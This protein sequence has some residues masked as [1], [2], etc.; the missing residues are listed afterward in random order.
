MLFMPRHPERKA[1]G[2]LRTQGYFKKSLPDK[3][4]VTVITV[5]YNGV[6]YL[7]ATIRSVIKQTH[8][9][10]EYVIIDGGS[11]D[12][13][14]DIIKKYNGQIDYW[15]SELDDGLYD[16][17]NKGIR[18]SNGQIICMLHS[19]DFYYD[20]DCLAAVVRNYIN[21][22]TFIV[23]DT[24]IKSESRQRL[25]ACRSTAHLYYEIPFMHPSSYI[26]KKIYYRYGLYDLQYKIAADV[27]MLMRLFVNKVK[28]ICLNKPTVVMRLGGLSDLN[29]VASRKEYR[30]IYLKYNNNV[31]MA[32][33]G[34]FLSL[35][36]RHLI[37]IKRRFKAIK[38]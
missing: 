32:Y 2:G 5:V 24:I 11:D 20:S 25:F 35:S 38:V 26:A 13:S 19:D 22:Q 12:G 34:Y 31:L 3:P 28:Y 10:V 17:M 27:D 14:L 36:L 4:L 15:I 29:F 23:T 6:Q 37:E 21:Y 30:S 16:A 8:D 7:E 9:N 1:E 33:V 18:L